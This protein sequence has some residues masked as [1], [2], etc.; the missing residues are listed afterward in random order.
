VASEDRLRELEDKY[1]DFKV[2]DNRGDKIGKVDDLFIDESDREEYIG[3]KLGLFGRRSTLIPME[4]VRVNEA[5]KTIEVSETKDHVKDAP[6]FDDD[7]DITVEYEERI[8]SHFGLET[9]G[10]SSR[11]GHGVSSAGSSTA[12]RE[13]TEEESHTSERSAAGSDTEHR[14]PEEA[15]SADAGERGAE[16]SGGTGATSRSGDD[17]DREASSTG[18]SG[19]T[20]E[21]DDTASSTSGES[22]AQ[23]K[24]V[25]RQTEE[26]ETFEEG[27]RTKIRRRIVSEEVEETGEGTD[28][29]R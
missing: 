3:V 14:S 23:E 7:D 12:E 6:N 16:T 25:S 8:R 10:S 1:E 29:S 17:E 27:G 22:G 24:P 4:I 26:T 21:H 20:G 11:G 13:T 5:E 28:T 19:V 18:G 9:S 2:Y 15:R